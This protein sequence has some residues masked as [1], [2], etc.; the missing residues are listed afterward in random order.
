MS[1]SRAWDD[2]DTDLVGTLLCILMVLVAA[3]LCIWEEVSAP[4]ERPAISDGLLYHQD[5]QGKET[6][7]GKV[8]CMG[9]PR[10]TPAQQEVADLAEDFRSRH[11][12]REDPRL[13]L[14]SRDTWLVWACHSSTGLEWTNPIGLGRH[15]FTGECFMD[16]DGTCEC[17]V[18]TRHSER[19][20]RVPH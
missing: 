13:Y 16:G 17:K 18:E 7:V 9:I 1:E 14:G 3:G 5:A 19:K 8:P 6:V 15:E 10:K 12:V 20:S 11:A 2:T 4:E